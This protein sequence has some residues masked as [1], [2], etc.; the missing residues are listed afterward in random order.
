MSSQNFATTFVVDQ[1]PEAAFAAITDVRGWWSG[2]IDGNTDQLGEEFT[3][4]YEDVHY[5]KQEITEFIPGKKIVWH[6]LDAYVNFTDDPDEWIGTDITFEVD[7]RGDHTEVGFTHLGLVPEFECF[8]KCSSAWGFYINNSLR[9]L[10][11]TGQ[12]APN[13]VNLD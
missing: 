1:T 2:E 13:P 11:T 10:I 7:R 3:Y 4:R 12:G 5:S 8:D 9:N 6:V